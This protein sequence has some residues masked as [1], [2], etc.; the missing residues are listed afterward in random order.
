MFPLTRPT[1]IFLLTCAL[2]LHALTLYGQGES[3]RTNKSAYHPGESI[4]VEF[5]AAPGFKSNAWVGIVPSNIPHGEESVNDRHDLAFQYLRDRRE[6]SLNFTAPTASGSYDLRMHDT[7]SSG[8]EVATT[9]FIVRALDAGIAK[10]RIPKARVLPGE[11]L[12]VEFEAPAGLPSNAWVGIVPSAI[13]HGEEKV[14][15]QHDVAFQYLRGKTA[16]TLKFVAPVAPGRWDLRMHDSDSNGR[17]LTS[18]T[19][20]VTAKVDAAAIADQLAASGKIA[21]Y[22]IRFASGQ[23]ALD[24]GAAHTLSEVGQMLIRDPALSLRIEGHTDSQGSPTFNQQLSERRAQTVRD[25]LIETFGLQGSRLT[26]QGLGASRPRA[27]NK[28][29]TGRSQNRRVELVKL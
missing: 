14:A 27:S 19:F 21:L 28:T 6:G 1:T 3:L 24:R 13:A 2:A 7:D 23:A 29:A 22:G 11:L 20:E 16:G 18:S 25:Y 5:V 12:T 9:S 4:R 10:L 26:T 17:E 8:K 15:D